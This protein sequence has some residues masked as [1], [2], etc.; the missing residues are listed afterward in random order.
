M[1]KKTLSERDIC[2]KFITPAI[3]AAGWDLQTQVR[4]ELTFTAGRVI[5]RGRLH[6]RGEK[7]WADYVLFH[8]KNQPIAVI[9]LL[10]NRTNSAELV[11]KT[12]MFSSLD[13]L[14]TYASYLIRI[15]LPTDLVSP[16]YLNAVMNSPKFRELEINPHVKQECGQANVN[17]TIMQSMRIPLPP[18]AEQLS[19]IAKV[20]DLIALANQFMEHL[21]SN[22]EI[23]NNLTSALIGREFS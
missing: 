12:G 10:Y 1:N 22:K 8:Q 9:H 7:R 5:V 17:G 19:V 23:L 4:E 21:S 20:K 11:G 16:H 6:S 18:Y 2:S 3:Q 15:R 13:D 14:Y